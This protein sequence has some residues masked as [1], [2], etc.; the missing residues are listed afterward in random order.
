MINA[1]LG[2]GI[3]LCLA[4]P[5][6]SAGQPQQRPQ[7]SPPTI[8]APAQPQL[9]QEPTTPLRVQ[10]V[11]TTYK[12]EKK[13]S[14]VP[15]TLS[16]NAAA[17]PMPGFA[18]QMRMGVKVPVPAMAPAT[19]DGKRVPMGGGPVVY[20]DIGTN[21]DCAAVALGDGRFQ[22]HISIEDQSFASPTG[23]SPIGEPPVI[24][25]FRL[26]NQV[27]LRDGQ[28]TQFTAAT[29]RVSGEVVRAEVTLAVPK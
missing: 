3:V 17:G 11:L 25:S 1:S 9:Q 18:A 15:Y 21:I 20:Q 7:P 22:L 13:L 14:S 19:V 26:S 16:V 6:V 8:S 12:D 5:A 29:D 2:F 28:S 23:L 4:M 10:L 24:R 27:T